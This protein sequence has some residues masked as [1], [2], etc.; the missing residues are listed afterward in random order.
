MF[1]VFDC[2]MLVFVIASG[3][4][5]YLLFFGF[6][7]LVCAVCV[8]VSC[9]CCCCCFPLVIGYVFRWCVFFALFLCLG[10]VLLSIVSVFVCSNVFVWFVACLIFPIVCFCVCVFLCVCVIGCFF[11]VLCNCYCCCCVVVV[12]MYV[13]CLVCCLWCCF[14]WL[15]SM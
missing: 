3:G 12:L 10:V 9:V 8:C 14:L 7:V 15:C 5:A 6:G 2:F 11:F 4:V 1:I 13:C